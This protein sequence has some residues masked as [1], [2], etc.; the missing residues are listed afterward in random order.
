MMRTFY[1]N[2]ATMICLL[3]DIYIH[4]YFWAI[5]IVLKKEKKCK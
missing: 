3:T 5:K 2:A 1:S 4:E